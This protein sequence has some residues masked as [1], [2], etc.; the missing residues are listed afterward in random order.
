MRRPCLIGR[1]GPA[2]ASALSC[3][4]VWV[5]IEFAILTTIHKSS[6]NPRRSKTLIARRLGMSAPNESS[7]SRTKPLPAGDSSSRSCRTGRCQ[8]FSEFPCQNCQKSKCLKGTRIFLQMP[9]RAKRMPKVRQKEYWRLSARQH[10]AAMIV[11]FPL[12][13]C[14]TEFIAPIAFQ[15]TDPTDKRARRTAPAA[16]GLQRAPGCATLGAVTAAA[17]LTADG[18]ATPAS[19]QQVAGTKPTDDRQAPN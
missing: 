16:R 6:Y 1:R 19:S 10:D 18:G 4:I 7:F 2:P 5:L 12:F 17:A 15:R 14:S 3:T 11:G 8:D 9:S 13:R